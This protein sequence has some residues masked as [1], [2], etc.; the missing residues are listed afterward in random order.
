MAKRQLIIFIG[1]AVLALFLG[2]FIYIRCRSTRDGRGKRLTP[3]KPAESP[4][5]RDSQT[6]ELPKPKSNVLINPVNP[7][8]PKE[9]VDG[10]DAESPC[11]SSSPDPGPEGG[12]AKVPLQPLRS[13]REVEELPETDQSVNLYTHGEFIL[14]RSKSILLQS[15]TIYRQRR[16]FE[17]FRIVYKGAETVWGIGLYQEWVSILMDEAI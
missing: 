6:P 9:D 16:T 17:N 4:K 14:D 15:M 11:G 12:V 3:P 7:E 5:P 1:L 2:I 10:D 8:D 13:K